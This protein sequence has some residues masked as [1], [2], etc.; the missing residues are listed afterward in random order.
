MLLEIFYVQQLNKRN[1]VWIPLER[2]KALQIIKGGN[3]AFYNFS[4]TYA[5]IATKILCFIR[6]LTRLRIIHSLKT[7]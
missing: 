5:I 2:T 1:F 3:P 4:I 6:V 7:F